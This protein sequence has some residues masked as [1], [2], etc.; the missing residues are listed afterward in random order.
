MIT[1]FSFASSA[2]VT[3]GVIAL[4]EIGDK[5]QLVCMTLAAKHRS[6][7][8]LIGAISA[9]LLLN[10]L[11]VS[12]GALLAD[13]I[14]TQW[15][16]AAAAILF[17]LFGLQALFGSHEED[18]DVDVDTRYKS[19]GIILTTFSMIFL[20]EL[21]DKTQ[22]SVAAMATTHPTFAVWLGSSL[23]LAFTTILGVLAGKHLLAKLDT[24]RLNRASGLFF[25]VLAATLIFQLLS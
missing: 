20:A 22:L 7:P 13:W 15:I 6:R 2:M 11:A 9:F 24:A 14:P 16:T 8:V 12:L 17:A 23:A 18:E 3:F 19:R 10:A 21:G 25:L 4:A 1:E 5:S